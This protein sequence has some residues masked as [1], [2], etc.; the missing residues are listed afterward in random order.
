MTAEVEGVEGGVSARD[1]FVLELSI[2]TKTEAGARQLADLFRTQLETAIA[3]KLDREQ[4]ALLMHS[5]RISAE[6]N[7][8]A[9]NFSLTKEEL[10][11]RMR[12]MQTSPRAFSS[13]SAAPAP[14]SNAPR[15]VKIYGLDDGVREIP[16]KP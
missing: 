3:T 15:T 9:L 11:Q 4:S 2:D 12:E 5:F 1:G 10:E 16:L 8:M 6:A 7:R 14:K 13:P